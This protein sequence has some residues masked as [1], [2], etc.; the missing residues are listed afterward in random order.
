MAAPLLHARVELL[1][2][3]LVLDDHGELHC[4]CFVLDVHDEFYLGQMDLR[5]TVL[6]ACHGFAD[7]DAPLIVYLGYFDRPGYF[8]RGVLLRARHG[9]ANHD[10]PLCVCLCSTDSNGCWAL[11][12]SASTPPL[13]RTSRHC[14]RQWP[15]P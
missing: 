4:M 2:A 9:V 1:H 8:D 10:V 12:L 3:H 13:S 14:V 11:V 15:R 7:L 6:R 5:G